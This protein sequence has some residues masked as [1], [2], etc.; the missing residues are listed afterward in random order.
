MKFEKLEALRG[1]AALYVVVYHLRI[2]FDTKL[3]YFTGHGQG[4]VML[5][6]VLS[7]FVIMYSSRS[8]PNYSFKEYFTKRFRRI[9]PVLI[10]AILVSYIF[11]CL[12]SGSLMPLDLSTLTGNLLNLQD[13]KRHPGYW[14]E[15]YYNNSPL[16]S[17]T[18]EWWFYM[19]FFP[20]FKF[21]EASYQKW[22][23]LAISVIGFITYFIYP[24]QI[25]LIMEYFI[26]WWWGVELAKIWLK[27]KDFKLSSFKFIFLSFGIMTILLLLQLYSYEGY[28]NT[29]IH[30]I[31][32]IK[33]FVYAFG[34]IV[35][36]YV[37]RKTKY[38]GYK[39][40]LKPF[41]YFAPISYGIYAFH[42]PIMIEYD[43]GFTS[44]ITWLQIGGFL[45]TCILA[46]LIEVS[47]QKH[48]NRMTQKWLN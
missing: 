10:V 37:W 28:L 19:I 22:L 3:I 11:A 14:F 16:W 20:I 18:Y 12:N 47:L 17:L 9:Y 25:S 42:F 8:K 1:I 44:N 32:E 4:A 39:F 6:F 2:G 41:L 45:F 26:I 23:A 34:L 48:I 40:T 36:G 30:P 27:H 31:L 13:M 33:H 7:G 46:H 5:F 29:A 21:I 35:F 43:F 38:L 24:N 15:P